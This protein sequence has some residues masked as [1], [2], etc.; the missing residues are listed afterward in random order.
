MNLK[1]KYSIVFSSIVALLLTGFSAVIF[2]KFKKRLFTS[3]EQTL[4]SH[5]QHEF[6]HVSEHHDDE[7]IPNTYVHSTQNVYLKVWRDE[8]LVS[9]SFP[10]NVQINIMPA[11]PVVHGNKLIAV[12]EKESDGHFY[13]MLGYHELSGY[14]ASVDELRRVLA[15]GC[16]LAILIIAPMSWGMI[17]FF[18][19]PFSKLSA[20]TS[21]LS[22]ERLSFRFPEPTRK[23]EYGT[24]IVNFNALL[25]RLQKAFL[26][27][28]RFAASVSHEFRT[29]L[30]VI[31]GE[32]QVMLRRPRSAE[33]YRNGFQTVLG[34]T[35]LL[36]SIITRLLFLADLER[37]E[38]EVERSE[39]HPDRVIRETVRALEPRRISNDS[40]IEVDVSES[41]GTISIHEELFASTI[42][43]LIE[44]AIKYCHSKVRISCRRENRQI[45]LLVDDDGPGI[46][47]ADREKVFDTFYRGVLDTPGSPVPDGHGLGLAIVKACV[48]AANGTISLCESALGGLSVRVSLPA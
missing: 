27:I 16:I 45:I 21:K 37:M 36:Q 48:D 9:D 43:N 18:L 20:E 28:K 23:D 22:A 44:N 2:L 31:Q 35:K 12:L 11:K 32:A 29:P 25:E 30:A 41:L 19:T 3:A 1:L 40:Q 33:E 26:Q 17:S 34:Q 15:F 38:Q 8:E 24:L 10:R 42:N 4:T 14:F 13:R 7:V 46:A 47:P 6:E 39:I 5:L